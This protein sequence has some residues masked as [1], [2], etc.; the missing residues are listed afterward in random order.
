MITRLLNN[1]SSYFSIAICLT[2]ILWSYIEEGFYDNYID[3]NGYL[4]WTVY[5][6][7][8]VI[9][10]MNIIWQFKLWDRWFGR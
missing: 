9:I 5:I 6:F 2:L 8:W 1:W 4:I 10:A 3:G 7:P